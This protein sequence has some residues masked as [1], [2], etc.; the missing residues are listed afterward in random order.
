MHESAPRVTT[1]PDREAVRGCR[2]CQTTWRSIILP[3]DSS[4][5]HRIVY[6]PS[7][8][9]YIRCNAGFREQPSCASRPFHHACH[10]SGLI[11]IP[12]TLSFAASLHSYC[13]SPLKR[14]SP[15]ELSLEPWNMLEALCAYFPP[16]MLTRAFA[17]RIFGKNR[18]RQ[19]FDRS[20]RTDQLAC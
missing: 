4:G 11:S 7:R 8:C 13:H 5:I 16:L 1:G 19:R 15:S 12:S 18:D 6:G 20:G 17:E 2:L 9:I 3:W 10:S 14:L